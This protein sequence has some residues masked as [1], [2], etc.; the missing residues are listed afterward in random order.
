MNEFKQFFERKNIGVFPSIIQD[1]GP[2]KIN[3]LLFEHQD[4]SKYK[5]FCIIDD[6]EFEIESFKG[7]VILRAS[8]IKSNLN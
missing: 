2:N 3:K 6:H 5:I 7:Q 1:A 8:A 4:P